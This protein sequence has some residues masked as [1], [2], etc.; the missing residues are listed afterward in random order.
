[1]AITEMEKLYLTFKAQHLDKILH[2]MQGFQ[3]IQIDTKVESTIT[4]AKKAEVDKEIRE[5]EKVLQEIQAANSVLKGRESTKV[6][7]S[8]K[9]SEEKQLSI[10][11]LTSIVEESNW[12]EI[13]GDIIH[14]DRRL[15]N[16]RARRLE[17]T[18]L[19]GELDIWEYL[20][21]DPLSFSA[22]RRST[23]CFGSVHVKHADDFTGTLSK[24]DEDGVYYEQVT[25]AGDRAYF[26]L[27]YHNS[28]KDPLHIYMNEFSFSAESYRFDKPQKEMRAELEKEEA[29]LLGEE[30]E[31]GELIAEEAKY[32]EILKFAE[33]YNLNI[34]LRKE[35]TRDVTYEGDM[36]EID[37]WIISEKRSQF[38]KILSENFES[39]EYEILIRSIMDTDI[40]E[41]P[42]KLK[43]NKLVTIYERLTELYSLPRYDEV[44]PTPVITVFYLIFYGMMVADVGYG[45]AVFL[46]GLIVKKWLKVKRSTRSF[47]DFLF[48]LSFPIMGWGLIYGSFCGLD[49][50]FGWIST[51][52]DS[53]PDVYRF[54]DKGS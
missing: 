27:L 13:L 23:A 1:M 25:T 14:T 48:Y 51:T 7:G 43:N 20:N 33:D 54:P 22:L 17:V 32:T 39:D 38:Q 28:M 5:I 36:I 29:F 2:L 24:H 26:F 16:N 6:L 46:V 42:I 8:L 10:N 19:F 37:G 35:K 40:D 53:F 45:L 11:E 12:V 34:L 52:L 47:V 15:Q 9:N 30:V 3:G 41:V 49:L 18:K 44:D 31:I 4:A 50:P 21:Y